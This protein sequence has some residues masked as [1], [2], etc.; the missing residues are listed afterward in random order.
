MYEKLLYIFPIYFS[1]NNHGSDSHQKLVD[2]CS[3]FCLYNNCVYMCYS[4]Y[5]SKTK[6]KKNIQIF[7][8]IYVTE[9]ANDKYYTFSFLEDIK[10]DK[11]Y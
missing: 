4:I 8:L 5:D 2:M 11:I 10:K 7:G 9:H 1:I 3:V 6:N